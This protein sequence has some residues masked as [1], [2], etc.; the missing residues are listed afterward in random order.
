[1]PAILA[2]VAGWITEKLAA[3]ALR[4]FLLKAFLTTLLVFA[5]PIVLNNFII[6]ILTAVINKASSVASG[7]VQSHIM[8]LTGVSAYFADLLQVPLFLSILL[9]AVSVRFSLKLLRVARIVT[10][11]QI[12]RAHV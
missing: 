1:M 12:G 9:G 6:G 11:K 2:V 8:Q 5:L 10:G 4:F 7:G 3:E